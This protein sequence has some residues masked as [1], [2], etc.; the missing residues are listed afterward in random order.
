MKISISEKEHNLVKR[1]F[2]LGR[3]IGWE[4]AEKFLQGRIENVMNRCARVCSELRKDN[5]RLDT[6]Y[7]VAGVVLTY[8]EAEKL[9]NILKSDK[10]SPYWARKLKKKIEHSNPSAEKIME[11][12]EKE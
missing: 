6:L 12:L 1:A 3:Q 7:P 11:M 5:M 9:I 2:A 4:E 8:V 10:P